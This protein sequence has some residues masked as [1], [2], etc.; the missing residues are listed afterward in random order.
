MK[1][2]LRM[3]IISF[4]L[5]PEHSVIAQLKGNEVKAANMDFKISLIEI[6]GDWYTV[7]SPL[8][9]ISFVKNNNYFVDINGINHG[10]GNYIFRVLGD[11]ISVNGTAANWPPYDCTLRLLNKNFLEIEFYQYFSTRTTKVR[12]KR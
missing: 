12:Y 4:M 3:G 5:F 7:D 8:Y 10:A 6:I 9:K 1:F 11:S 2:I